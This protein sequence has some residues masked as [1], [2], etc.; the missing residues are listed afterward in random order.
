M[1]QVRLLWLAIAAPM[2]ASCGGGSG[3]ISPSPDNSPVVT[4]INQVQGPGA[5]SPLVNRAVTVSG[6]VSG[7]FQNG[8]ADTGNNLG[9]FFLQGSAPDSDPVTSEGV[10]VLDGGSP[11]VDVTAG[12]AV[13]VDGVV[14]EQAGETRIIA[15]QVTITGAGTIRPTDINLPANLEQVEGMLIRLPQSLTVASLYELERFGTVRVVAGG[16]AFQFTNRSPPD[17]AGFAAHQ[18]AYATSSILLD[19]GSAEQSVQPIRYLRAGTHP[20]YS[21]RT[22]DTIADLTGNVRYARGNGE[23]GAQGYRLMPTHDVIF[24]AQNPRPGAP[25]MAGS[26]RVTSFNALNFFSGIDAGQDS[27]GPSGASGCRGADSAAELERQLAKLV[28]ALHMIDA[29]VIGLIEIE[30]N[31]GIA[32][33]MIVERLNQVSGENYA[34]VTTGHIGDSVITNSL[35][36]KTGTIAML[37]SPV[38]LDASVDPRFR[39][40]RNRPA[41]AQSFTQLA[42][43]AVFS[44]VVNHLK[45][46]GSSCEP[47]GDPDRDDGQGNCNFTRSNAAA[48]LADWVALDPTGSGDPDYLVIGDLNAYTFEDPLTT[49]K[50]A[51]LTS[52]LET[53]AGGDA[54]SFVFNGLSGALDHALATPSLTP[55]VAAVVEWHI[56]ADEPPALDYNLEFGRDPALFDSAT[57][58]RASDHD[59]III[60][61]DLSP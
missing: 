17:V 41:L 37:G 44:V 39:D 46:K 5:S 56:N 23:H 1:K 6:I 36:F 31:A 16:R 40:D 33:Q 59:P 42:N 11:L 3:T 22:G 26:V 15:N 48:A 10:F 27:C 55:Q 45:S 29:D 58:W 20:G 50:N 24:S 57:P 49:L 35:L 52:L 21:I 7:D 53:S 32:L 61:L 2:L 8:D 38:L 60:G 19:D 43:G 12:D 30:N 18:A 51:G 13:T 47:D 4:S 14:R 9:G 54:W 25:D 28:T 34:F